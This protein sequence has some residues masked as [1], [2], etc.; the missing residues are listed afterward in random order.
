MRGFVRGVVSACA[1]VALGLVGCA[2]PSQGAARESTWSY[3]HARSRTLA[4]TSEE[5]NQRVVN[6]LERDR[7]AIGEDI[8]ILFMTDRPTRLTKWHDR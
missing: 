3:P 5:H 6:V 7:R 8:D 4:E 1:L 2:G